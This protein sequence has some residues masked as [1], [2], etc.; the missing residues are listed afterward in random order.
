MKLLWVIFISLLHVSLAC[1][2]AT[3]HSDEKNV[4][5]IAS[6]VLPQKSNE[7]AI[8][9]SLTITPPQKRESSKKNSAKKDPH[10]FVTFSYNE[11]T[12]ENVVTFLASKKKI[13]VILPTKADAKLSTKL[14]WHLDEKISIDEAWNLLQTILAIAGY[15]I[16]SYPTY[17]EIKRTGGPEIKK[18]PFHLYVNIPYHQLPISNE[19]IR[20]IYYLTNIK[21][22]ETQGESEISQIL[23]S[24]LPSDS[25]FQIDSGTNALILMARSNDI[26][27][28]MPV[29]INL[30]KPGF[31][32]KMEI[33]PLRYTESTI[34]AELFNKQIMGNEADHYR[35]PM[36]QKKTG[37]S[38]FFPKQVR[39]VANERNN[40]LIV[41]GRS[42]AI[43][44]V[45]NFIKNYIDVP[46][47]TGESV[48]HVYELQYLEANKFAEVLRQV[49]TLKNAEG[50]GQSTGK[51][52]VKGPQRYFDEVIIATDTPAE[53]TGAFDTNSS[54]STTAQA[55]AEPPKY[56]GG[57]RLIIACRNDDWKRIEELIGKLDKPTPQVLIE[58]LIADLTLDDTRALGAALRNPQKIPMPGQTAF[59]TAQLDP[60]VMPDSFADPKTIGLIENKDGS[61]QYV[62][63]LLRTFGTQ[64]TDG[65]TTRV[66][67]GTLSLASPQYAIPGSTIISVSDNSGK[68]WGIAQ[69]L[70]IL[71]YR[72]VLSHPHIL[73]TSNKTAKIKVGETRFLKGSADGSNSGAINISN[74]DVAANLEVQFIP[75]IAIS[76]DAINSVNL[77]INISIDQ[78]VA[79][80]P[81]NTRE[82]R[83]LSTNVT[84]NDGDILALGGLIRTNE[85][86]NQ[87]ETPILSKIPIIGWAFKR[88]EKS[89][90]RT[91]LTVFI[92]PTIILPKNR[93][94]LFGYTKD[95]WQLSR[96]WAKE[97]QMFDSL[98]DPIT[99]WFFADKSA[100]ER[101]SETFGQNDPRFQEV[102]MPSASAK[103]VPMGPTKFMPSRKEEESEVSSF[104]YAPTKQNEESLKTMI[105][106]LGNP[107]AALKPDSIVN[108]Q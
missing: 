103:Q 86:D 53:G 13:N 91:N 32:E 61:T 46:P 70:K 73:S 52:N 98:K 51:A 63:D 22:T 65:V 99:R 84:I 2:E 107:F 12:L 108:V 18:E 55:P 88:K 16:I 79:P 31:Q 34:V 59:Q 56:S 29:I 36:N 68:T 105:A 71:D 94:E 104:A 47:E 20:Y 74:E 11:E 41:I 57:N 69:I 100:T 26:R 7:P 27:G 40:N 38:S 92:S 33:I 93:D 39:I 49:L 95:Y 58:V 10:N 21:G 48:L 67:D 72:K 62:S 54:S 87:R 78:Y 24:W 75:R 60:G 4:D 15:S 28:I 35:Y 97:G 96:N 5:S 43:D 82:S 14:T 83:K 42:Q 1:K 3:A 19:H 76:N 45:R 101:A 77:Q 9:E 81:D 23:K 44:R 66:D 102:P 30:D 6:T 50:T 8:P 85:Q 37:E 64:T 17:I 106:E 80:A 25:W 89:K 90:I